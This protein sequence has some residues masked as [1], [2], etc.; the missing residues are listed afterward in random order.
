MSTVAEI[1]SAIGRLKPPEVA[2]LAAWF[3]EYQQMV[4]A[5]AE[6]F[7][8]YDREEEASCQKPAAGSCR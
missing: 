6:M 8:L 2:Q 5:S 7:A 1:E 4:H 3:D